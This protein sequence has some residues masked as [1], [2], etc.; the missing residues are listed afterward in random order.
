MQ[1]KYYLLIVMGFI[2]QSL[3]SQVIEPDLQDTA[4]CKV[5]NRTIEPINENGK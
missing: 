2:Q 5:V 1:K 4:Q 3:Y